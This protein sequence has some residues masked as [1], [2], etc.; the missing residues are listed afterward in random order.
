VSRIPPFNFAIL[1]PF[2]RTAAAALAGTIVE[3][4]AETTTSASSNRSQPQSS[5]T[6]PSGSPPLHAEQMAAPAGGNRGD[7]FPNIDNAKQDIPTIEIS[8]QPHP[9]SFSRPIPPK[10]P[11]GGGPSRKVSKGGGIQMVLD[12]AGSWSGLSDQSSTLPADS[13]EGVGAKDSK[14][15]NHGMLGFLSRKK[16]RD[17]SP[18]PQEPGILGKEGARR[19]IS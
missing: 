5:T 3:E 14:G 17:R 7:Y 18:K 19:I 8:P 12:G 6:S 11:G 1:T 15:G 2:Y 13:L 9:T 16:G 4:P 10:R